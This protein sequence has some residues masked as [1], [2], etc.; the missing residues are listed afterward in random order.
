MLFSVA[1]EHAFTTYIRKMGTPGCNRVIPLLTKLP[2]QEGVFFDC[3]G[4]LE[5]STGGTSTE[6]YS[7][8]STTLVMLHGG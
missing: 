2:N 7:G 1:E 8:N 5:S 4:P 6:K 3:N